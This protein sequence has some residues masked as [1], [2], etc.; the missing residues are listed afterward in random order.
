MALAEILMEVQK[1]TSGPWCFSRRA[2][3]SAR[4][5]RILCT[6]PRFATQPVPKKALG[7]RQH[8]AHADR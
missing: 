8:P 1:G 4:C 3:S 7:Q 5:M 2:L 6:V